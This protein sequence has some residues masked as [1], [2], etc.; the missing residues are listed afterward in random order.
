MTLLNPPPS[1]D[2]SYDGYREWKQWNRLFDP[3]AHECDLF[4]REFRDIP[5][6][7]KRLLDI[8]FGS[9]ALLGWASSE[10][11]DIAGIE[12]QSELRDAATTRGITT[13]E[14]L[15]AAPDSSFDVVTAF[16]VLEHIPRDHLVPFLKQLR[17]IAATDARIVLRVPNCQCA[18]GL[19]NQFGDAT[20]VTMLSGPIVQQLCLQA[21]LATM[22]V[23]ESMEA[24]PPGGFLKSL[25]RPLQRMTRRL[26]KLAFRL[27]WSSGSTPLSTNV[28]VIA[29]PHPFPAVS[30]AE[31]HH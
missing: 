27:M 1:P 26:A 29:A 23:R 18:A 8:G 17:R 15:D 22:Q 24:T 9:G 16:D 4:H 19:L 10:G 20:H 3:Q 6:R 30:D 11:A 21:G 7:N 28:T 25:L 12:L 13:Y 2:I 5:L 14:S 31:G